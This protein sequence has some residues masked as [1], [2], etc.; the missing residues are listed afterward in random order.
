MGFSPRK[1]NFA[2]Y[3]WGAVDENKALLKKLGNH[4]T[5]KYC[6]Y[7]NRLDDIDVITLKKIIT[8]GTTL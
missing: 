5:S 2:L 3:I 1:N 7:I 6:L 4:K 8:K